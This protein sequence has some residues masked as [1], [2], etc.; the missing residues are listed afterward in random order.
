M[1]QKKKPAIFYFFIISV[2]LQS[3]YTYGPVHKPYD[4]NKKTKEYRLNYLQKTFADIQVKMPEADISIVED[5]IKI[6][7]PNQ[8]IYYSNEVAPSTTYKEPLTMLANLLLNHAETNLLVVGHCDVTGTSQFNKK[9]SLK[10][11]D[12][13]KDFLIFSGLTSSKIEA[14]G[15]GNLYPIGDN[16]TE[17]GRQKNRRVEF[18]VLYDETRY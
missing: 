15:L 18:V 17:E 11:A 4:Y 12:F 14:W 5:S 13:I 1:K 6:L 8:I 16:K 9:L 2:F 3:C 10:R 7:F